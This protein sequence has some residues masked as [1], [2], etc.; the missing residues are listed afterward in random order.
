MWATAAA[1]AASA[2]TNVTA[3]T[4]CCRLPCVQFRAA[5]AAA[6]ALRK[7]PFESFFSD[8]AYWRTAVTECFGVNWANFD[9]PNHGGVTHC[10]DITLKSSVTCGLKEVARNVGM[11]Y[12]LPATKKGRG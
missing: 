1:V 5:A 10:A 3:A 11:W 12:V 9:G 8:Q 6:V 2:A 7:K 4:C